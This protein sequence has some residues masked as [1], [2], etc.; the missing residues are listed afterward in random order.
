MYAT[1]PGTII[2][3]S[4]ITKGASR[5]LF[6]GV[7][8][9]GGITLSQVCIMTGLEP[10]VIQNWIKRGFLSPP[11]RRVY[12][13]AQ[14]ARIMLINMLKESLQIDR[15]CGLIRSM[16]GLTASTEDDLISDEELYHKYVDLLAEGGTLIVDDA[17]LE[18]LAAHQCEDY[19]GPLP[20]G[21]AA[22]IRILKIM[23]YAHAA[24]TFRHSAEQLI[25]GLD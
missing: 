10:Y 5:R 7:F 25:A 23:A 20:N 8:A 13:R 15:I 4:E 18:A 1:Y 2:E 19:S 16:G 17:R 3:V 21:R 9:T 11:Q 24:A 14:L 6:D 22:L 12:S